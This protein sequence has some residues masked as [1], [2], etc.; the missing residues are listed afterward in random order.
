M[1]T[2]GKMNQRYVFPVYSL[3]NRIVGFAGRA[4]YQQKLPTWKLIGGK[5]NWLYP[6]HLNRTTIIKKKEVI[7]VEGISDVLS[8]FEAGIENVMCIFGTKLSNKLL[9]Y[10]LSL[11]L[12]KIIIATNNEPDNESIGNKA[13]VEIREK[14]VPSYYSEKSVIIKLPPVKDFNLMTKQ[15]ILEWYGKKND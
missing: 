2:Q 4:I 3:Q 5:L 1:A 8:F 11:N 10:L 7:L 9:C 14:L 15:Q 12:N 13:A 6:C